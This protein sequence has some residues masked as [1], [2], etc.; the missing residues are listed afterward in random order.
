MYVND[1]RDGNPASRDRARQRRL[2]KTRQKKAAKAAAVQARREAA[3]TIL[4]QFFDDV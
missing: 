3:N 4:K 2:D 1:P